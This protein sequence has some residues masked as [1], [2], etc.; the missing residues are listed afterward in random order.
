MLL[1]K[2]PQFLSDHYE[3][4][5]KEGIHEFLILTRFRN[6]RLKIVDFLVKAYFYRVR[7]LL[8]HSV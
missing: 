7:K 4:L 5:T 2:N 8:A 3:I 6:D 1:L